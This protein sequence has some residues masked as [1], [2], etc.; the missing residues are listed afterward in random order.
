MSDTLTRQRLQN[1][2]RCLITAE[3]RITRLKTKIANNVQLNGIEVD[4]DLH[5]DLQT[6][7]EEVKDEIK[8]QPD[9][10]FQRLFWEQQL[11]ASKL[12]SHKQMRW[13]PAMI[14]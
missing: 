11:Q 7:V 6:L 12:S 14:R 10:S 2:R 1:V 3:K 8:A 5:S 9:D 13:H 4:K